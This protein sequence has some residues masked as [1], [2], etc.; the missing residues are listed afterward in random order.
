[1]SIVISADAIDSVGAKNGSSGTVNVCDAVSVFVSPFSSYVPVRVSVTAVGRSVQLNGALR[2][3][4]VPSA[5][6][7]YGPSAPSRLPLSSVMTAVT[8]KSSAEFITT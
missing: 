5:L 7:S 4:E 8:I 3:G 1:M 2:A 6:W